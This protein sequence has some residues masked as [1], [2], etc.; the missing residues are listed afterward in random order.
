MDILQPGEQLYLPGWWVCAGFVCA[1]IWDTLH[2]FDERTPILDV[3]VIYF[4]AENTDELEEKKCEQQLLS[5]SR[6]IPW[7]VKNET[8]MHIINS[9]PPYS[10]S[11]DATSKFPETA[12]ALS[13]KLNEKDEI[14]LAAPWSVKDVLNLELRPTPY[15]EETREREKIYEE[16]LLKKKWQ[17]K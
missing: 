12:T 17:E 13:L 1:K 2:G 8:R 16:R 15:F 10:S 5:M 9:I 7:S 11:A 14:V 3:D 4:D 6:N